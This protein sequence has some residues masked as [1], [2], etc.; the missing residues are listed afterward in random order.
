MEVPP[1]DAFGA[2]VLARCQ[3]EELEHRARRVLHDVAGI[4]PEPVERAVGQLVVPVGLVELR[5]PQLEIVVVRVREDRVDE[6]VG[7]LGRRREDRGQREGVGRDEAGC[8]DLDD[9]AH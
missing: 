6:A 4:V 8:A 9:V 7:V 1:V 3:F 2:V 5:Q